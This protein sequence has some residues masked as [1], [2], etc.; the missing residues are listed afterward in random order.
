[1]SQLVNSVQINQPINQ[2]I[3]PPT[4][5]GHLEGHSFILFAASLRKRYNS[6]VPL[7][8]DSQFHRHASL[9][10]PGMNRSQQWVPSFTL[11]QLLHNPLT[12]P[13]SPPPGRGAK[14]Y[15]PKHPYAFIKSST[16]SDPFFRGHPTT[17]NYCL[18]HSRHS[19]VYASARSCRSTHCCQASPPKR[20]YPGFLLPLKNGLRQRSIDTNRPPKPGKP[21]PRGSVL[22]VECWRWRRGWVAVAFVKAVQRAHGWEKRRVGCHTERRKLFGATGKGGNFLADLVKTKV[23]ALV[24]S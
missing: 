10:A 14:K 16:D 9:L 21:W 15:F 2:S 23:C 22:T 20:V 24:I 18:L 3:N 8:S 19:V 4:S 1:M 13:P 12:P 7:P 17:M 5:R 11:Q 6:A